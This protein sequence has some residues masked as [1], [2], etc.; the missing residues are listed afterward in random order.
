MSGYYT[1][2]ESNNLLNWKLD[3]TWGIINWNISATNLSWTNTWDETKTS[4]E[5]KLWTDYNKVKYNPQKMY[6]NLT[7]WF[8]PFIT[9]A[10]IMLPLSWSKTYTSYLKGTFVWKNSIKL[11]FGETPPPPPPPPPEEE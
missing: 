2:V 7:D 10:S 5:S 11:K 4:I 9:S 1:K 3:K 8:S 6:L